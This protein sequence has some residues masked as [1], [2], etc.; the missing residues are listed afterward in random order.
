MRYHDFYP[1]LVITLIVA[2]DRAPTE[3][4]HALAPD[5][6][7]FGIILTDNGAPGRLP[8][9][10]QAIRY[11]PGDDGDVRAGVAWPEPRFTD[12]G[13][14]TVTD[15]LTGLMWLKD[16]FSAGGPLDYPGALEQVAALA[17]AGHTDWRLPNVNEIHSM[18][19]RSQPH[20]S[21]QSAL[22]AGH[23]IADLQ[24]SFTDWSGYWSSTRILDPFGEPEQVMA[25]SPFRGVDLVRTPTNQDQHAWAVRGTGETGVIRVHRTGWN[26]SF[27]PEDDGDIQAGIASPD[28][29]FMDLGNGT[30][31]DNLTGLMWTRDASPIETGGYETSA[32]GVR[33]HTWAEAVQ[34][35]AALNSSEHLHHS[36]WRLPN[37]AE[38]R[39]LIDYSQ[40]PPRRLPPGAVTLGLE[41]GIFEEVA[42]RYWS[43][44]TSSLDP[45]AAADVSFDT[46]GAS[47][48]D[49]RLSHAVWPVRGNGELQAYPDGD[50]DGVANHLDNCPVTANADQLDTDGDGVGDAC[51]NCPTAANADQLDAD[52]DGVG[53][54]CQLDD[55]EGL[56]VRIEELVAHGGLEPRDAEPL[57]KNL[58]A[59]QSSIERERYEAAAGQLGAFINQVEALVRSRRLDPNSGAELVAVTEAVIADLQ[60]S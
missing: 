46:P 20:S 12:H 3:P 52:G 8:V 25:P 45:D 31:V 32:D 14:G 16:A 49:K 58:D 1:L 7:T 47:F 13:D 5:W 57:L 2:C 56:I 55:V 11:A 21:N 51:D 40:H 53:D 28:P 37:V 59:A 4:P 10:G 39:S 17:T 22:P 48:G 18:F 60:G 38:L 44:T 27:D 54:A 34:E 41:P 23:P 35:I 9:T 29:R 24:I 19:D 50:D 42:I 36:D 43:S 15:H 6:P 30:I 33:F 26:E